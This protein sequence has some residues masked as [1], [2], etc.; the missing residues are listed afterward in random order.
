M[1][2][3]F[4]VLLIINLSLACRHFKHPKEDEKSIVYTEA[5]GR[6]GNHLLLYALMYQLKVKIFYHKLI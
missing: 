5:H 2:S 4:A 6:L 1:R 3:T